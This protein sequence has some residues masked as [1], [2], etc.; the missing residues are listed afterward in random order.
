[1]DVKNCDDQ[2]LDIGNDQTLSTGNNNDSRLDTENSEH[3]GNP[4][5]DVGINSERRL[6][7]KSVVISDW[8]LGAIVIFHPGFFLTNQT[9]LSYHCTISCV[10]VKS[11]NIFLHVHLKRLGLTLSEVL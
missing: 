6:D 11:T 9:C 4:Q 7:L 3:G 2:Q 8:T 5:L 1:M 10:Y